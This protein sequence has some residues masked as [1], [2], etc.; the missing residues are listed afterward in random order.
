MAILA[1][2]VLNRTGEPRP[3]AQSAKDNH[4]TSGN[5]QRCA[6]KT[7]PLQLSRST[8]KK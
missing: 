1:N 4:F 3:S 8:V 6:I 7:D 2:T 5:K